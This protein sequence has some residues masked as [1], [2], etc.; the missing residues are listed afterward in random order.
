MKKGSFLLCVPKSEH[1]INYYIILY[2]VLSI[3]NRTHFLFPYLL[4]SAGL[5]R[6]AEATDA[7]GRS[8]SGKETVSCSRYIV[9]EELP[10]GGPKPEITIFEG[11]SM[12]PEANQESVGPDKG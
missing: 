10:A 2:Y 8:R 6:L 12:A 7:G 4:L 11:F 1:I 5:G 3:I 9:L